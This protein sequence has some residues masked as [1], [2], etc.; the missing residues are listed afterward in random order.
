MNLKEIITRSL[1]TLRMAVQH[2][3]CVRRAYHTRHALKQITALDPLQLP[4][5]GVKV[6]VLDFDGVLAA[7]G[8]HQP[9]PKVQQWLDHCVRLL[10]TEQVF[11]LSNQPRAQRLAW[12]DEQYPGVRF[13]SGV[14]KKPYPDGLHTIQQQTGVAS[15]AILLIDDRLLTGVLAACIAQTQVMHIREPYVEFWQHPIHEGFFKLLR[16]VEK[17]L[18][19]F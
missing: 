17:L 1:Y 10:G 13:I 2:W 11:I 5:L 14:R 12:F 15:Q 19:S 4:D 6:L 9:L 18:F 8:A 3:G 7:D 16:G